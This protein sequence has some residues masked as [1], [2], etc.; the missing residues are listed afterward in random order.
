MLVTIRRPYD[1]CEFPNYRPR[2]KKQ[3]CSLVIP[4]GGDDILGRFTI[5]YSFEYQIAV[6]NGKSYLSKKL[7]IDVSFKIRNVTLGQKAS[8]MD[9]YQYV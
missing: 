2:Q 8:K 5:R 4:C 1:E 6:L 9:N 7:N 3:M